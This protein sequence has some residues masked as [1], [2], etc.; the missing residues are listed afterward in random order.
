M[1]ES[2]DSTSGGFTNFKA[3]SYGTNMTWKCY[4]QI[5]CGCHNLWV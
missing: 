1:A 4:S 3:V 5:N 2:S